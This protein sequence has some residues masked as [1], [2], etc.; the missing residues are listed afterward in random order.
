MGLERINLFNRAIRP[1]GFDDPFLAV[2][3]YY[4]EDRFMRN[5]GHSEIYRGLS[6]ARKVDRL[7]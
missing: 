1:F 2:T 6:W 5:L 3:E 4:A 7:L